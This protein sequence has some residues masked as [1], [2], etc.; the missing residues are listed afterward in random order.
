MAAGAASG[1]LV[2]SAMVAIRFVI[3]QAH[4]ASLALWRYLIGFCCLLPPVLLSPRVR[5]ERRDVFPG[6]RL[7]DPRTVAHPEAEL[8]WEGRSQTL[9]P[10]NLSPPITPLPARLC[11]REA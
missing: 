8:K 11:A 1:I 3:D 5:F 7:R 2:G 9:Y 6:T 4:P 10:K